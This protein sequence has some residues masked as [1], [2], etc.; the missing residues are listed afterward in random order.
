M[1]SQVSGTHAGPAYRGRRSIATNWTAA[2]AALMIFGGA[3][4]I[5]EGVAAILRDSVFASGQLHNFAYQF[6][7]RGWGITHVVIGGVMVL[8]GLALFTGQLWA[9]ILGVVL[10]SLSVIA[11][12]LWLPYMPTWAIVSL[13]IDGFII[14][15]LCAPR[16]ENGTPRTTV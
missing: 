8:A 9:R 7:L 14:W 15:A 16:R 11:N 5:L 2:G 13:L 6:S 4:A 3:V 10:A 1:A 12:F